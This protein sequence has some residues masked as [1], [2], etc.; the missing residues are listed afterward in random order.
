MSTDHEPTPTWEL[1]MDSAN[2]FR[3]WGLQWEQTAT[4]LISEEELMWTQGVKI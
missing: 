3:L 2:I 1:G 4:R